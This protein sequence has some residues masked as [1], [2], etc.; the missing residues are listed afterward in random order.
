M[1][2]ELTQLGISEGLYAAYFTTL[3][4]AFGLGCFAVAAV[5]A[6]HRST[7][8]MA[9]FISL[10]LVLMGAV[11]APNV[12]ALAV[13]YPAWGSLLKF[14]WWALWAALILFVFLFPNGRF[15]PRWA[16]IPVI[17]LIGG[18]F[19]AMFFGE[20]SLIE[21]PDALALILMGGLLAGVA[22]Q[23]YRY[24]SVSSPEGRQQTKWVVFGIMAAVAVQVGACW[25]P[26][27][28][29]SPAS[30]HCYTAWPT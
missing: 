21:P 27:C 26:R 23:I 15:A 6:W 18:M 7:D 13:A 12:Q 10:F 19:I 11:N 8:P 28:S 22:A 9:L 4:V 29:S 24:R 20:G 25:R 3:L 30:R 2:A 16:K 17:L 5:I 1:R 14:S